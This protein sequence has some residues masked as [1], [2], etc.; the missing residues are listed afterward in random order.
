M[1]GPSPHHTRRMRAALPLF[2]LAALAACEQG[3]GPDA[4]R[5]LDTQAALADYKAMQDVFATGGW[6]GFQALGGRTPLASSATVHSLRGLPELATSGSGRDF[7]ID[8]FRQLTAARSNDRTLARTVISPVHLGKTLVYDPATDQYVIDPKRT[9]AP[10]NGTR[11][12]IYELDANKRPIVS[13]EIG[14]ADLL[15][16][17]ASTGNAIVL[18]L[19]VV[20]HGKTIIDYRASADLHGDVGEIDVQGYAQD[21]GGTRLSFTIDVTARK[22][23]GETR[24]DA[25]FRLAVD[26]RGFEAVGSARGVKEGKGGDGKIT[27]TLRHGPNTLRVEMEQ[28]DEKLEGVILLNGKLFVTVSGDAKAPTLR[29]PTGEPLSEPELQVVTYITTI[30]DDVFELV[31]DLVRPVEKLLLL[32]WVL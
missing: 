3:T 16:E 31:E 2:V 6:A 10:S 28:K 7:A 14:Y 19:V 5:K 17:G 23:A 24:I 8:F 12:I 27:L 15:D 20:E 9:G 13:R 11:F 21:A 4:S 26:S 30:T 29:G 32:G 1:F 25:D 22:V 18:R